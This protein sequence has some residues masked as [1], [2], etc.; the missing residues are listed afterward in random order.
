M[1]TNST[2][3]LLNFMVDNKEYCSLQFSLRKVEGGGR[4]AG[5]LHVLECQKFAVLCFICQKTATLK[6][7]NIGTCMSEQTV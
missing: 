1:K 3:F 5:Y 6:I 7:L 2:A 4:Y